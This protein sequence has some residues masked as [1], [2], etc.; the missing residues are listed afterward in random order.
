MPN[1]GIESE[2]SYEDNRHGQNE[3]WGAD[4]G[5]EANEATMTMTMWWAPQ[6]QKEPEPNQNPPLGYEITQAI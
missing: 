2:W 5:F 4:A 3:N 1:P 6:N